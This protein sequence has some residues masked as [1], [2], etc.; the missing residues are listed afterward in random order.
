[1]RL[2]GSIY[3]IIVPG[4]TYLGIC[5]STFLLRSRVASIS[6]STIHDHIC[7]S[8]YS[9]I[10]DRVYGLLKSHVTCKC[11]RE[12]V[13]FDPFNTLSLPIPAQPLS[14][15]VRL[16]PQGSP[17]LKVFIEVEPTDSVSHAVSLHR[18]FQT[19]WYRYYSVEF[20][21]TFHIF[22]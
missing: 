13:T 8:L 18:I 4:F 6:D 7:M 2:Y 15:I 17:P 16:L 21:I 1:M 12:S 3:C 19:F 20:T 9:E 5:F 10:V 14:V 11:G 22:C